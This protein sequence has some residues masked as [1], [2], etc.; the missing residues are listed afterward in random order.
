MTLA[1]MT[2][3]ERSL[4]LFLET[5]AVDA[6]R[7]KTAHMN[8]ED[9][10]IAEKWHQSGFIQFGRICSEDLKKIAKRIGHLTQS[11]CWCQ[12]SEEA[13]KLAHEERKARAAR[14]WTK[15]DWRTT[16]EYQ[17]EP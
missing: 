13:W 11:P 16:A 14:I 1:E 5:Q 9:F 2:K 17:A 8:R 4:L 10:E 15:R 7:V 12:L 3:E 6:G